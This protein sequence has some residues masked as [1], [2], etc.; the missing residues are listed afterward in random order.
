MTHRPLQLKLGTAIQVALASAGIGLPALAGP[1]GPVVVQADGG[2]TFSSNPAAGTFVVNQAAR[3][4]VIDFDS[5]NIAAG[6][7]VTF[8]LPS[9]QAISVARVLASGAPT[10]IDG[11]LQSFLPDESFGGNVWIINPNGIV[12]GAN[13]Q[14]DVHGLLA[15]TA[16]LADPAGF[17]TAADSAPIGFVGAPGGGGPITIVDGAEIRLHGG[18]GTFIVGGGSNNPLLSTQGSV[19]GAGTA[20]QQN[21]SQVLFGSAQTFTL[22]FSAAPPSAL[23]S[24]DLELF[25]FVV[26]AT[27][28][29]GILTGLNQLVIGAGSETRAG[30]VILAGLSPGMGTSLPAPTVI[31]GSLQATAARG[32]GQDILI[33]RISVSSSLN[34]GSVVGQVAVGGPVGGDTGGVIIQRTAQPG[35]PGSGVAILD[36]LVR[37]DSAGGIF[38]QSGSIDVVRTAIL[39]SGGE[40]F[41]TSPHETFAITAPAG[42]TFAATNVGRT[43]L[44]DGD[45][46]GAALNLIGDAVLQRSFSDLSV[47]SLA[48]NSGLIIGETLPV[49]AAALGD[50]RNVTVSGN[51]VAAGVTVD[52]RGAINVLGSQGVTGTSSPANPGGVLLFGDAG[53]NIGGPVTAAGVLSIV[54]SSGTV[55]IGSIDAVGEFQSANATG[56]FTFNIDG[57]QGVRAGNLLNTGT[58][59]LTIGSQFG[60][61]DIGSVVTSGFAGGVSIDAET[62]LIFSGISSSSS[63]SL[64]VFGGANITGGDV[65]G[66]NISFNTSFGGTV[67]LGN[68]V[69]ITGGVGNNP[70]ATSGLITIASIESAGDVFFTGSGGLTV[71][72]SV[73]AVGSI[74]V[75]LFDGDISIA[76]PAIAGLEVDL[77][78]AGSITAGDLTSANSLILVQGDAVTVGAVSA[79][80]SVEIN[81]IEDI[82][83]QGP[84]LGATAAILTSETGSVTVANASGAPQSVTSTTGPVVLLG[85][86]GVTAGNLSAG[87][88]GFS[89]LLN[90]MTTFAGGVEVGGDFVL[91]GSTQFCCTPSAGPISLGDINVSDTF[92]FGAVDVRSL[93]TVDVGQITA[94]SSIPDDQPFGFIN[95]FGQAGVVL[96][97]VETNANADISSDVFGAPGGDVTITG[98]ISGPDFRIFADGDI[99]VLAPLSISSSV[100]FAAGGTFSNSAPITVDTLL[101]GEDSAIFIE[102]A[103]FEIGAPITLIPPLPFENA[104]ELQPIGTLFLGD[105]VA[106]SGA[107][108]SDAEFQF[109]SS[110]A[111]LFRDFEALTVGDL[112]LDAS[113][114]SSL[115]V[116]EIDTVRVPGVVRGVGAPGFLVGNTDALDL[117]PRIGFATAFE[118]ANRIEVT[119][120]LG[121]V[122]NPLG[123]VLLQGG[124][125]GFQG[126]PPLG[127]STVL[128]G[129]QAFIDAFNAAPDP[130]SFDVNV[131][132]GFG[133]V[134]IGQNFIVSEQLVLADRGVI[135]QQNTGASGQSAGIITSLPGDFLTLGAID[136]SQFGPSGL[137]LLTPVDV[138][139]LPLRVELFGQ[140]TS[141]TGEVLTGLVPLDTPGIAPFGGEGFLFP[142]LIRINAGVFAAAEPVDIRVFDSSASLDA[143][144][145]A[146][147]LIAIATPR[148]PDD[149]ITLE[150]EQKE[151]SRRE[152]GVG[153]ANE[154]LWP[155]GN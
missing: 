41:L 134:E 118:G 83:A 46:G 2:V 50:P 74:D 122:E 11:V 117:E 55:D 133:G 24:G 44:V 54:S 108:I 12:F 34:S 105:G 39:S 23:T 64:Q 76:G 21:A 72:G 16:N 47:A 123:A 110:P 77:S 17:V 97:G 48:I 100:E 149:R 22:R 6:E 146:S 26:D 45:F 145:G 113:R 107:A 95:I 42:I 10:N 148:A 96:G 5:F 126:G 119:G 80:G 69:S 103:D 84:V 147:P 143:E 102:A 32:A 153:V 152:P 63:V 124:E 67:T 137:N 57:A 154:D 49:N 109:L 38:I 128:I 91:F 89:F 29:V 28:A 130:L 35:P 15:T 33:N 81:A 155:R 104:L 3:R 86:G 59:P 144:L 71:N 114:I 20:E 31:N 150:E 66:T 19:T 141:Q 58:G 9:N 43:E 40:T 136:S 18:A 115:F 13:A 62:G 135:L 125:P 132:P 52:V 131:G 139:S 53:V 142:D 1:I 94:N 27:P 4:A 121:T 82:N 73:E 120:A 87:G 75:Q 99:D 61:V 101:G 98:P 138:S 151:R 36:P 37:L 127:A 70:S 112:T 116:F 60:A 111:L 88:Q 129:S 106:G 140:F 8:N 25:D 78:T 68:L 93:S 7:S 65:T 79:A 92:A 30:Q 14:V 90:D 85:P 56:N 51:L